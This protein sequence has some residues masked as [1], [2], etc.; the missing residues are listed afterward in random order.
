MNL[1]N[2]ANSRLFSHFSWHHYP[3]K[4]QNYTRI[5]FSNFSCMFLDPT[6]GQNNF[7]NKIPFLTVGQNNYGNKIPFV[8]LPLPNKNW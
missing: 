2:I 8:R 6:V 5:H 1:K 3:G 4:I 7:G